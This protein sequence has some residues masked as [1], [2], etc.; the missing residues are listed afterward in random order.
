MDRER[1]IEVVHHEEEI[2]EEIDNGLIRLLASF[3]VD[4]P[5]IVVEFRCLPQQAVVQLVT[6]PLQLEQGV[7]R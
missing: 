3:A 5:A 6:F 1:A 2:L 4:A 7:G